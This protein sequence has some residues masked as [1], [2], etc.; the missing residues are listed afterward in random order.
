MGN[1]R[2]HKIER[3]HTPGTYESERLKVTALNLFHPTASPP[4]P[5]NRFFHIVTQS[6]VG[7]GLRRELSRTDRA[8]LPFFCQFVKLPIHPEV[9]EGMNPGPSENS[10]IDRIQGEDLL[11]H[12]PHPL[13]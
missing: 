7:R 5:K 2:L 12:L 8:G 3:F 13:L 9:K 11:P 10:F 1:R 4:F 6:P